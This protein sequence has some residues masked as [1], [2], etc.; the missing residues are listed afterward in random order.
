MTKD[1]IITAA[2]NSIQDGAYGEDE[3]S[4]LLDQIAGIIGARVRIPS[5]KSLGNFTVSTGDTSTNVLT[6][7][8]EFSASYIATAH[9]VTEGEDL[10][11][12]PTLELLFA[13]YA[14]FDEVGPIEAICFEDFMAWTQKVPADDQV[15]SF[16]YYGTPTIPTSGEL[17]W[18]P[19]G[20][21]RDL[22]VHGCAA[23]AYGELEDGNEDEKVNTG[24]NAGKFYR[25]I[26][27]LQAYYGRQRKHF[28]SGFWDV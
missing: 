28:V 5:T 7:V 13:D 6:T 12:Y 16:I 27:D 2:V 4:E 24:Y 10:R 15:I 14:D 20:L 1:Q 19:V 26:A 18:A 3:V 9:N 17:T 21:H 22:F 23:I 25:A 11:I 8:T